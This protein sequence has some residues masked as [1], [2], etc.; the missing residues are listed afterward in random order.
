MKQMR[1]LV[2]GASGLLGGRLATLLSETYDVTGGVGR[3]EA[4]PGISPLHIEL[5][6]GRGLERVLDAA[7][8][9]A[10]LH[11]AAIADPDRCERSPDEA[12]AVN[13]LGSRAIAG[14]CARRGLPLVAISTDLVFAGDAAPYREEAPPRPIQVYG[15]TKALAEE[16]ILGAHP[17]AAVARVS[18]VVGRGHGGR[19]T[20]TE[21][22]AR[23]LA[24]GNRLRLYTDQFRTPIDDRSIASAVAALL[25]RRIGG[26]FHLGGALRM[27]RLE[28]GLAVAAF[29]GLPESL[30][31]GVRSDASPQGALRP[32]DVTLDSTRTREALGWEPRPL[33]MALAEGRRD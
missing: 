8:P 14:Y 18:L 20:A 10:V 15:L 25:E 2:T 1:V 9:D 32:K 12:R 19:R 13:V 28:I 21:Q 31:E 23:G 6:G 4:P 33:E 7:R 17:G 29:L 24:S 16:E 30:L 26:R 3:G 5:P 22:I 27:S 11:S